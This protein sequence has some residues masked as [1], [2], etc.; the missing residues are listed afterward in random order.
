MADDI[1]LFIGATIGLGI[2]F[3]FLLMLADLT[4]HVV[5]GWKSK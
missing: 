2:A 4:V 5:K 1:G 3:M